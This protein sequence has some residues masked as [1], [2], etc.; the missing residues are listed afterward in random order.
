MH[1]HPANLVSLVKDVDR[2]GVK[3]RYSRTTPNSC[4]RTLHTFHI[5]AMMWFEKVRGGSMRLNHPELVH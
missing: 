5:S 2:E 1:K 4:G 3:V